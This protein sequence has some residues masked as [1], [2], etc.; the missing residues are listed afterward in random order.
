[1]AASEVL[2]TALHLLSNL[3][4]QNMGEHREVLSFF[5]H[6]PPVG[7]IPKAERNGLYFEYLCILVSSRTRRMGGNIRSGCA[8]LAAYRRRTARK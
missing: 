8:A 1:M 4:I 5:Y 7:K 2:R 3:A 6:S